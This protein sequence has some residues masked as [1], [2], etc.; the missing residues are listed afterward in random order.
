MA[1]DTI[2]LFILFPGVALFNYIKLTKLKAGKIR[3]QPIRT[4]TSPGHHEHTGM[5]LMPSAVPSV[6]AIRVLNCQML[7]FA[8]EEMDR[9]LSG[10]AKSGAEDASPR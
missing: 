1:I 6:P 4:T 2:S 8:D 5:H 7:L 3:A 9:M 10:S